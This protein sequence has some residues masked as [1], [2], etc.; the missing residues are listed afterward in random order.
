MNNL[1]IGLKLLYS[2][3]SFISSVDLSEG[4]FSISLFLTEQNKA[5]IISDFRYL[6]QVNFF[7]EKGKV[8]MTL[9]GR[10]PPPPG[11]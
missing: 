5:A 9:L 10:S 11:V 4:S 6:I 7:C 2:L 8:L 1:N 3:Y